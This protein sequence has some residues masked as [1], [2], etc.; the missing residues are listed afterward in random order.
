MSLFRLKFFLYQERLLLCKSFCCRTA[1]GCGLNQ[2]MR[3]RSC[4]WLEGCRGRTQGADNL[5]FF[6]IQMFSSLNNLKFS[7][8]QQFLVKGK[9]EKQKNLGL[10][11]SVWSAITQYYVFPGSSPKFHLSVTEMKC[12]NCVQVELKC[13]ELVIKHIHSV[14][15]IWNKILLSENHDWFLSD[16]SGTWWNVC[17]SA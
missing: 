6:F 5:D 16:V 9:N 17:G 15:Q 8:L 1:E 4:R 2:S 12:H 11:T 13:C 14:L 7:N 10:G 3:C